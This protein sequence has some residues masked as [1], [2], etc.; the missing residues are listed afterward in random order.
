[1]EELPVF[2]F[3]DDDEYYVESTPEPSNHDFELINSP[4]PLKASVDPNGPTY[5]LSH[6]VY[7]DPENKVRK[8]TIRY[9]DDIDDKEHDND[10]IWI[11]YQP[12][13][14]SINR[15]KML[16]YQLP[17]RFY[18][19]ADSTMKEGMAMVHIQVIQDGGS[20]ELYIF[21]KIEDDIQ[22]VLNWGGKWKS[23]H[24]QYWYEGQRAKAFD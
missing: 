16:E 2:R 7:S 17:E 14:F 22:L 8:R 11:K 18:H 6:M 13:E 19:A 21:I 4:L 10:R 20:L 3:R 12:M 15:F 5:F 23:H 1:M 9:Y 24:D